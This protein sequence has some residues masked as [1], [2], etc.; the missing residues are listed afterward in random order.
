MGTVTAM[1]VNATLNYV[2]TKKLG[3]AFAGLFDHSGF[4]FMD[5]AELALILLPFLDPRN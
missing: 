1:T 4:E 2:Y 3:K 5:A